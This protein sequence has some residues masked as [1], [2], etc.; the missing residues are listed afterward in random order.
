MTKFIFV[1]GGVVSSLGKGITAASLG[2]LLKD[3][4]LS[5]TIQKFDPYLNVDP[6][7]MSPY[8]HGEVFVTDDG[9]ETDLDLGHYERF[10]DINLN[11]YSNVTAGKV[12]SHVLKKERRGDY[13]GGTVQVIPHITNEIKER[14]LLAGESTKADVVITEIGGTTGDIESLPFIE[15]IRQIRS[16]LGRENVMYIHCTLLPFIKAAGEMKTKPTQHSV[17]ELRGLGIQPDLIVVRTEYEM[18][19][20]LKDKIALFCDIPEQNVIECRDAES[21]YEIPLQLSKQHM[22][23]LVIKRLDLNAKYETQLDEWKHL[24]DVVN[25]L[26]GEIT[27]GLVGKYVSLQDAYLSVVEA[28]KHAGY[29]LHKDINVKWIDSSEVTDENAAEYLK[30]VD[31]ILVPGGFGFRASEGKISAIRYA[32]ENNVPYFGICL[33]MQLAT[34]EFARNVLGLEGAHSAELDPETPYPVIDLLPEQKD[35]EDLG[36]TL[37]LGLYPS[38]VKEGTLAYDIY[39][40]KEI[41]ERHRHRYEFN[42]DYREQMEENG[43]VFSGVSP[44]G[45]RIEMVE[46]PKNDF[47]F[48]C[49][50]HPEF[51]SRPNRPQP[52]FKAFIEAANKYK[53]AKENK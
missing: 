41:E 30:D 21:L 20:D 47:F 38:E 39:G 3:R 46:L 45:R 11:K 9:A 32:R 8:Q 2:R 15:A 26:D 35:I 36:G 25:H 13:L 44:D 10:I 52:I 37:R 24:L 14:L 22:D 7:T 18:T 34:V 5:V 27:I 23:D 49:Q 1:T 53:E 50:F 19:Q 17:K 51:L 42:N 6:G 48:A 33:G 12:Y 40:K 31:G 4:G 28:L 16:D 29:P 43:L